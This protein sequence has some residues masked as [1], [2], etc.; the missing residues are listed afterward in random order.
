M[1][2]L[3]FKFKAHFGSILRD[4]E[5]KL[6]YENLFKDALYFLFNLIWPFSHP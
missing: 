3:I 6:I 2:L 1:Q 4:T 5:N